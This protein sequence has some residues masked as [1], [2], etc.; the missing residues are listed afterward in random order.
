MSGAPLL[1]AVQLADADRPLL[2]EAEY[3]LTREAWLLDHDEFD[4]W[5]ALL[6][7]EIRYFAPVRSSVRR[8]A[9]EPFSAE[10]HLAHFDD[11]LPTLTMRVKR[12]RTGQAWSEDP[13]S[14]IRRFLANVVL[15][16][17]EG[18]SLTV[19]SNILI[20]REGA[21]E[22]PRTFSAYRQDQLVRKADN[23]LSLKRR[24]ILIDHLSPHT[25]TLIF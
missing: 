5:L 15:L 13:R 19:G 11:T 24:D 17:K 25:L 12:F 3:F 9:E 20:H 22:R 10:G 4:Q 21:D 1:P 6:D 14:R 8:D 2:Q 16:G 7:P 23:G 18:D